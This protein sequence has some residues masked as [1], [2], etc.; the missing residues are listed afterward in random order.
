MTFL[1]PCSCELCRTLSLMRML[2]RRKS[3]YDLKTISLRLLS[4]EDAR[5]PETLS[6]KLRRTR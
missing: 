5:K 3:S 2:S 1:Q 4:L 6:V